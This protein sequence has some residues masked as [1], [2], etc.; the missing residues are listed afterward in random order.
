MLYRAW[1]ARQ[2]GNE[3]GKSKPFVA[4][5]GLKSLL[6]HSAFCRDCPTAR[7][8]LCQGPSLGKNPALQPILDD[9]GRLSFT[10]RHYTPWAIM[11]QIDL[12]SH[13]KRADEAAQKSKPSRPFTVIKILII[14]SRPR[15]LLEGNE[16]ETLY[17]CNSYDTLRGGGNSHDICRSDVRDTVQFC[18]AN[19]PN[20]GLGFRWVLVL[21]LQDGRTQ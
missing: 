4:P 18:V 3:N 13:P 6:N 2:G 12:I 20:G 17:G 8:H 10:L 1:W 5:L 21:G 15:K 14:R 7:P 11:G 9:C 16:H 19:G